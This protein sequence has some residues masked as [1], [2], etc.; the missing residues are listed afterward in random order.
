MNDFGSWITRCYGNESS[1]ARWAG[2]PNDTV[3]I[4]LPDQDQ[5]KAIDRLVL[6]ED[7]SQGAQVMNYTVYMQA[8]DSGWK[9][10]WIQAGRGQSVG[11]KRIHYLSTG[12]VFAAAIKVEVDGKIPGVTSAVAW[13]G[14]EVHEPCQ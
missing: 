4:T 2:P 1:L 8:P 5:T 12:P 6:L 13:R 9:T 7:Q 10:T 14:V 3:I 11:N